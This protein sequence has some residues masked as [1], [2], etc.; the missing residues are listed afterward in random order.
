MNE[1]E[2]NDLREAALRRPLTADEQ[3][4]LELYLTENPWER[5]EWRSEQMITT[6][7][8]RLPTAPVS[9]NF[10]ARVLEAVDVEAAPRTFD[11]Q[12]WL[13]WLQP[14]LWV[15][16]TAA[17]MV[18]MGAVVF[19]WHQQ[20]T[21]VEAERAL[22]EAQGQLQRAELARNA[23]ELQSLA[24]VPSIE[25]L[26]DFEFIS[27]LSMLPSDVDLDLLAANQ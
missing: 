18:V 24:P 23:A 8:H 6:A 19:A 26:Q 9:S 4:L 12:N 15:R 22:G 14:A 21:V 16:R 3:A 5:E 17:A 25:V 1:Q 7:I 2:I 20:Q 27:R 10:T 11:W 13:A